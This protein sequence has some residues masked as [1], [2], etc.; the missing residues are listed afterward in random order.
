MQFVRA[1][2]QLPQIRQPVFLLLLLM[3]G[4]VFVGCTKA[5][6]L[7]PVTGS[8]RV[9]GK[10]ASGA[11]VV[12]HPETDAIGIASAVTEEDGTFVLVSIAKPGVEAGKY[13][14]TVVWPDMSKVKPDPFG[15]LNQ[16]DPPDQLGGR[17]AL[18][19]DSKLEAE[20]TSDTTELPVFDLK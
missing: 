19:K 15:Q 20:I 3:T 1:K 4:V 14:V 2:L 18:L 6:V 9:K 13:R 11:Q 12:F 8:V 10:P 16:K 5:K 7:H 17:F